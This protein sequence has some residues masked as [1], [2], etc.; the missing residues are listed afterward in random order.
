MFPNNRK[1]FTRWMP[2]V[3]PP[4]SSKSVLNAMDPLKKFVAI[5]FQI[6]RGTVDDRYHTDVR[7]MTAGKITFLD[8]YVLT[9]R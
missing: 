4:D 9:I 3:R 6:K 2:G 8:R 1:V 7:D 5:I